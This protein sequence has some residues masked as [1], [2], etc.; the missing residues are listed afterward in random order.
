MRGLAGPVAAVAV[1][2]HSCALLVDGRV[3]CWGDN[4][5]GQLG[6]GTASESHRPVLVRLT[7]RAIAIAV[8]GRHSCAIRADHAAL[9]WGDNTEG[10]LGSGT[11]A[12]RNLVPV[13]VHD[14]GTGV[15]AI[16]SQADQTCA[17]TRNSHV[18]C[19]GSTDPCLEECILSP[20]GSA[21]P[22]RVPSLPR[23]IVQI[24]AGRF[25][26]CAISGDHRLRC[27]EF[28]APER[29]SR[30][31]AFLGTYIA[32]AAGQVFDCALRTDGRVACWDLQGTSVYSAK[33]TVVPGLP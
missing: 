6:D 25:E 17:L 32:V 31:T 15:M 1:G 18:L 24:A 19:W 28:T 9:C 8:G 11:G 13:H 23:T 30:P 20:I 33:P 16:S 14:L 10:Q 29:I 2:T 22:L 26:S 5:R 21:V 12:R 3:E 4:A 27:W 7:G